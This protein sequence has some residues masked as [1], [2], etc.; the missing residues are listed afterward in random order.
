MSWTIVAIT[1]PQVIAFSV[2]ILSALVILLASF[3][4]GHWIINQPPS[5]SPYT[6]RPLRSGEDISYF[7]K[8]RI[9]RSLFTMR[10]YHNRIF[11]IDR[12]AFCRDTG[13]IFPDAVTWY[14]V[15]KLDWSFLTKRY[16]GNWVSWGSLSDLQQKSILD[17]HHRVEGY[18]MD[19]SCPE[20]NPRGITPDYAYTKP[21]PLYV[22]LETNILLGWKM[23]PDSDFEIMVVQK[24]RG[25]FEAPKR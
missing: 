6:K 2:A 7:E 3:W 4:I 11:D 1:E 12:A 9:L 25:K 16:P 17:A 23:V 20:P 24:P 21:G 10:E 8:E 13:R 14:D 22:D 5:L 15:I 18:Q 19:Y